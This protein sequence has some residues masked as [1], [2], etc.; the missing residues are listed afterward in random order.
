MNTTK[1][2]LGLAMAMSA[3]ALVH[4]AEETKAVVLDEVIVTA[5]QMQEPLK[6]VT[7]PKLPRQPL[8]GPRRCRLSEDHPRFLG[9]PQRRH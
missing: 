2:M 7:D 6:V 5:P 8:A 3:P 1:K 4:G 9:D